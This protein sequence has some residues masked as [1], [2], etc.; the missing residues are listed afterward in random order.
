MKH[1]NEWN[2]IIDAFDNH[3]LLLPYSI[4]LISKCKPI[5]HIINVR[6]LEPEDEHLCAIQI[7]AEYFDL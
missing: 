4:Y 5:E 1:I 2:D 6:Y 3:I 7:V